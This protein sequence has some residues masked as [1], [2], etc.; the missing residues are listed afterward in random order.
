MPSIMWLNIVAIAICR[1][2]VIGCPLACLMLAIQCYWHLHTNVLDSRADTGEVL[3]ES[4][5]CTICKLIISTENQDE[6]SVRRSVSFDLW[7][8]SIDQI[9]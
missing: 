7:T 1:H 8:R 6:K 5:K 2:I 4:M 3:V 9:C